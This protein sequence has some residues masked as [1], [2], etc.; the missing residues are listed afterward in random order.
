LQAARIIGVSHQ[1][2]AKT[3]NNF[4]KSNRIVDTKNCISL[5]SVVYSRNVRL[6]QHSEIIIIHQ[7]NRLRRKNYLNRCI[8]KSSQESHA[9]ISRYNIPSKLG[10]GKLFNLIK[11]K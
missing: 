7:S 4:S 5:P 8:K 11:G 2:P 10:V 6:I 3:T 1:H 9:S